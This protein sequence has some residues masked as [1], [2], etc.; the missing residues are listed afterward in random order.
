M[1]GHET[2]RLKY[3]DR[4]YRCECF[5]CGKSFEATRSDATF[6]SAKCRVAYS[7]EPQ[8][9]ENTIER[10]DTLKIE[11]QNIANKYHGNDRVFKKVQEL[12]KALRIALSTFDQE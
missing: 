6:C 10:I 9:L 2:D 11:I 5:Q 3:G 12:E 1:Q 8:K 7:R 4:D